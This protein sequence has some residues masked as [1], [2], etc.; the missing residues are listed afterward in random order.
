M[1]VFSIMFVMRLVPRFL[2][3]LLVWLTPFKWRLERSWK[4]LES[5]VI[6]EVNYRKQDLATRCNNPD[7]ISWMLAEAKNEEEKDG[8]MLTRLVGSVIAGGTYSSAAFITGVIADL[9]AHPH[10]LTEIRDEIHATHERCNGEWDAGAFNSLDKLDSAM[11]E[12]SRLAPGSL[13]VYS[14]FIEED[15][16]LSTGLHLHA[17]QLITTSGHSVAMDPA[18]FPNPRA[19]DAL[20][21][22][23]EGLD[24][25]RAQPFRSVD[26]KDH[27]WGAGRWACPG[28][29]IASLI[30]KVIL[31][32][33]LDEYDFSFVPDKQGIAKRPAT[34]I[35]HEFVFM[36]PEAIMFTRRREKNSGIVF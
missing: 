27:R 1:L 16:V 11:K 15:V 20:R 23:N 30:S 22:F 4:V 17:G 9:V 34:Q 8:F 21:A 18:I 13:L 28:R 35:M 32:K 33:L 19:Y 24:Q 6:P 2:Q 26:S 14:R 25:H 10:F 12:T 31:V 29:S 7:L 36:G 5:F 3:P